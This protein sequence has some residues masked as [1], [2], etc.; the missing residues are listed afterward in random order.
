MS[1]ALTSEIR[2]Q[3]EDRR[4]RLQAALQ[5]SRHA[6]GLHGLLKEVDLALDK[7]Q[8][9]TFG[10]CETC[11]DAIETDRLAVDPLI[12]NCLAHLTAEEQRA[13][14]HDLDLA[15]QVQ[16]GLLPKTEIHSNGWSAVYRYEPAGTVGGDYCDFISPE[17]NPELFYFLLGDV[18]G[19]GVAASMLVAHLHAIFRSLTLTNAQVSD[20]VERANRIFCEGT[21]SRYFATLACAQ[22]TKEG[23]VELCN[24]GHCLPLLIHNGQIERIAPTGLPIGMFCQGRFSSKKI[25]MVQGDTLVLYSDGYSEAR[26]ARNDFYGEERLSRVLLANRSLDPQRIAEACVKDLEEFCSGSQKLDDTT[27]MVVRRTT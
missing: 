6:E 24:A 1:D 21:T 22:A 4:G 18:T 5:Q 13:L 7:L 11:H 25:K 20:L 2:S 16:H 23:D 27:I 15:S 26:N 8:K 10:V 19:K 3:L 12:R 14:E 17:H 9:G